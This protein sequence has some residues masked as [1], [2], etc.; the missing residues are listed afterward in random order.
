M[1]SELGTR[2]VVELTLLVH[3]FRHSHLTLE[4]RIAHFNLTRLYS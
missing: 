2:C 4:P 1:R 3:P